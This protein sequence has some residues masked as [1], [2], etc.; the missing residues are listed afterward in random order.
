MHP[1]IC[2][3]SNPFKFVLRRLLHNECYWMSLSHAFLFLPLITVLNHGCII[4]L[5]KSWNASYFMRTLVYVYTKVRKLSA[6]KTWVKLDRVGNRSQGSK[7]VQLELVCLLLHTADS[8][9]PVLQS[10]A[11]FNTDATKECLSSYRTS[12]NNFQ[13]GSLATTRTRR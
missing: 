6:A 5:S 8:G 12:P 1:S 11:L 9:S 2:L 10:L 3:A 13:T 7:R 4:Y